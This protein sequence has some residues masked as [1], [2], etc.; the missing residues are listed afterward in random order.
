MC[1]HIKVRVFACVCWTQ[2]TSTHT[3]NIS[4]NF[5]CPKRDGTRR[6]AAARRSPLRWPK[7]CSETSLRSCMGYQSNEPTDSG[8]SANT[9]ARNGSSDIA[10]MAFQSARARCRGKTRYENTGKNKTEFWNDLRAYQWK[11]HLACHLNHPIQFRTIHWPNQRS[12]SKH[13]THA[14]QTLKPPHISL[15][16]ITSFF[17]VSILSKAD[18]LR[19]PTIRTHGKQRI[20][21]ELRTPERCWEMAARPTNFH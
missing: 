6:N 13:Y 20:G 5:H 21:P 10:R 8:A 4:R 15:S 12:H 14:K 7:C 19:R 3:Q 11:F 17:F 2:T 18:K 16:T 9:S 1:A